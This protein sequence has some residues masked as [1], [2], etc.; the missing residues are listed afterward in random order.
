MAETNTINI[1]HAGGELNIKRIDEELKTLILSPEGTI[2]GSRNFGLA[3]EFLSRPPNEAVNIL[4]MELE[5]KVETFI[6][7]ITIA[8][9]EGNFGKDIDGMKMTIYVE[10]TDDS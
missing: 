10:G 1:V 3:G 6:P 4:A 2:P 5:E 8:N 9:V 7:E